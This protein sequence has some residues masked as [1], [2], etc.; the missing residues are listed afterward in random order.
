MLEIGWKLEHRYID[1]CRESRGQTAEGSRGGGGPHIICQRGKGLGKAQWGARTSASSATPQGI[2]LGDPFRTP[3]WA[4]FFSFPSAPG[5]DRRWQKGLDLMDESP[6]IVLPPRRADATEKKRQTFLPFS[7]F[8]LSLPSATTIIFCFPS[9][10]S[11]TMRRPTRAPFSPSIPRKR[12]RRRRL[13]SYHNNRFFP[14]SS[15]LLSSP[16]DPHS[17]SSSLFLQPEQ[18]SSFSSTDVAIT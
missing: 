14:F 17:P 7:Q 8:I 1:I 12:R 6:V 15:L 10:N 16:T 18:S 5:D 11:T 4:V 2:F 9:L 3:V 13:S